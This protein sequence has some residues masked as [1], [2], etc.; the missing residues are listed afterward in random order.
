MVYK[1][2]EE[3]TIIKIEDITES[4]A[5][6]TLA[7]VIAAK[8]SNVIYCERSGKLA[9]MISMGDIARA[10]DMDLDTV[11]INKQFTYISPDEYMKAK[12]IFRKRKKVNALPVMR[13]GGYCWAIIPGGMICY[14]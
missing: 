14:M 1:K 12:H 8:P 4:I 6:K 11:S 7:K 5:F 10:H 9:G 13:G 3:L 2:Y